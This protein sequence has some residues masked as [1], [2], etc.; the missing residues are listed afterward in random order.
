MVMINVIINENICIVV[1]HEISKNKNIVYAVVC[2]FAI[3]EG[4]MGSI[5]K[6]CVVK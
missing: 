2:L 3:Y 1:E 6:R 4:V 5:W